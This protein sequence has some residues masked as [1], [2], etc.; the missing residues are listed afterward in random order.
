MVNIAAKF[1]TKNNGKEEGPSLSQY[2]SETW[3]QVF[4]IVLIVEIQ[5]GATYTLLYEK[6]V[7][8]IRTGDSR[9]YDYAHG[10]HGNQIVNL[11][12]IN[13]QNQYF[14]HATWKE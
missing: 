6:L 10:N 2:V 3:K 4:E 14:H 13:G 9:L 5:L 1:I 12:G 7:G 8:T 11:V